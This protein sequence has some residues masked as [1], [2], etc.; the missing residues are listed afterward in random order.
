MEWSRLDS[1]VQK[2]RTGEGEE[3]IK[4]RGSGRE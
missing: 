2:R 4:G 3:E 1:A